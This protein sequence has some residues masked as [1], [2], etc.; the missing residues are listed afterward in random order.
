MKATVILTAETPLSFRA[1]R[2]AAQSGTL[3]YIPGTVLRGGLAAAHNII[4]DDHEEFADFFLRD[5]IL[6]GN[7]YPASFAREAQ[8]AL[9][10][11]EFPVRPLPATARTCKRFRGF[12]FMADEE[13]KERHGV[14]DHLIPWALFALSGYKNTMPLT[15]VADCQYEGDS[16][17]CGEPIDALDG[18]YRRG[19]EWH[20]IGKAEARKA[21]RTRTGISRTTG[22]AREEI[23]YSREV[24]R[25]GTAFWGTL[26]VEDQDLFDAFQSFV[27]DVIHGGWLRLGNNRTRGFGRVAVDLPLI[28]DEEDVDALIE[29][30]Q[31]FDAKLREAA[32]D[33]EVDTPHGLYV[34]LTLTSDTILLDR[35]LRYRMRVDDEYLAQTWGLEGAELVYQA[36]GT[37]QLSGWSA[38]WGLPKANEWLITKGSV[39]LF[40]FPEPA[41]RQSFYE[42]LLRIQSEGI[43]ARRSEG[44]GEVVVADP[45]HWEV[46][47]V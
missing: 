37:R 20:E 23:L 27:E 45:F 18:F 6:F 47:Q 39:F 16:G 30:A 14:S 9:D 32:E 11:A 36:A 33:A 13:G 4:R 28:Q 29:R 41:D 31:T 25:Q 3:S 17:I 24:L 21:I 38:L 7:L 8:A 46:N 43:G 19:W 22:A 40:G 5:R 12:R 42:I 44:F 15:A 1:G 2:E 34:P 35:L 10:D 26:R